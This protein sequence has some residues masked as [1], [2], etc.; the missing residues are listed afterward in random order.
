MVEGMLEADYI[1]DSEILAN[2]SGAD[3][4]PEIFSGNKKQKN[5]L[6]RGLKR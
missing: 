4:N 1:S 2:R 6:R 3:F 5:M